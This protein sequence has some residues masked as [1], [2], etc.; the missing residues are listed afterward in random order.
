MPPSIHLPVTEGGISVVDVE[1]VANGHILAMDKGRIGE[2]YILGGENVTFRQF[3]ETLS[4]LTALAPPG[5]D[6]SGGLVELAGR[7][8]ELKARFFGGDP[9]LTHRLARDYASAYAWA[10]SEKAETELGYTHRPARETLG[11]AVRWYL[12][13]GYVPERAAKRVRLELRPT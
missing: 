13:R 10:T 3:F 8:M 1:D 4:E 2:R 5:R 11:R 9:E 12:E 7:L 6:V